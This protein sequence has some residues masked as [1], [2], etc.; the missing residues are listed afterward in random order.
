M[1]QTG[2]KP[3]PARKAVAT[4]KSP[5]R[6]AAATRKSPAAR[7][8]GKSPAA[9]AS[10]R[11]G[12]DRTTKMSDE[13]LDSVEAGQRAAIE[14]VR[15]FVD[16]VDQALPTHGEGPSRRQEVVDSA[17][18]MADRLVHTQYEFIRNMIDSA[19]KSL[20]RPDGAK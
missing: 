7:A 16:T 17:L 13:V 11:T 6:K 3:S 5:A 20:S 1:A 10:S 14:A 2:T 8:N 4:R 15:R 19:G 18:E 12:I 9:P